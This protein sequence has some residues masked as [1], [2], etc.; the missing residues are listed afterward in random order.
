[1]IPQ[2]VRSSSR[3]RGKPW[4]SVRWVRSKDFFSGLSGGSFPA[5]V[6]QQTRWAPPKSKI[7]DDQKMQN[8]LVGNI[9]LLLML[10]ACSQAASTSL[11]AETL[12]PTEVSAT[13]PSTGTCA[14]ETADLKLFTNTQD[15]YCLLYPIEDTLMTPALIVINPTN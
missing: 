5:T 2:A 3:L 12:V 6:R 14:A 8:R 13:A 10:S 15:G 9:L 7:K 1:M 4:R 11:P